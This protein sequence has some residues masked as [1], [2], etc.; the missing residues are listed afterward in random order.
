MPPQNEPLKSP[1]RLGLS[2][3]KSHTKLRQSSIVFEKPDFCLK[4]WK[5]WRAPTTLQFYI[6]CW[7]F[8][9]VSYLPM[10]TTGY[11]EFFPF[12]S[13]LKLFAKITKDL[14]STHS[15]FTFLLI[16]QDLKKI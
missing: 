6:F 10:S 13:D 12:C 8:A 5:H 4:I 9:H 15:L 11:A 1:P 16:I 3:A 2:N 14:V 7:T